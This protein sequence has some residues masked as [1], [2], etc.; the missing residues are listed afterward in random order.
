M[1]MRF[2]F[3]SLE[4]DCFHPNR[5]E[6]LAACSL[7]ENGFVE[8]ETCYEFDSKSIRHAGFVLAFVD[9]SDFRGGFLID[10]W[11]QCAKKSDVTNVLWWE[12][13]HSL[14]GL[15]TVYVTVS[16]FLD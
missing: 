10:S 13:I 14:S 2:R 8:A 3:C 15:R 12:I 1:R 4:F 5:F 7:T 11:L 9:V 6:N 16:V